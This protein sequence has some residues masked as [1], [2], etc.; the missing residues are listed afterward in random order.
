MTHDGMR[1]SNETTIIIILSYNYI[2]YINIGDKEV[3]NNPV[4]LREPS[5]I[6]YKDK[7]ECGRQRH[8]SMSEGR[9]SSQY[10]TGKKCDSS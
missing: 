4:L 8:S 5:I 6:I 9:L 7:F 2:A 3:N 10:D 1:A